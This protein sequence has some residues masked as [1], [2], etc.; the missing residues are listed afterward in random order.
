MIHQRFTAP[1]PT[2]A[3]VEAPSHASALPS[4]GQIT[5]LTTALTAYLASSVSL[6]ELIGTVI[7]PLLARG[8]EYI[9]DLINELPEPLSF[10]TNLAD[11]KTSSAT[12]NTTPA[13][14]VL[15]STTPEDDRKKVIQELILA[16]ASAVQ[17]LL[18]Y[19]I[20]EYKKTQMQPNAGA[21]Q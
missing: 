17:K 20:D 15:A 16:V 9:I 18:T 12:A 11:Q 21:H 13:D 6:I 4:T 2:T 8:I 7:I 19:L 3:S 10:L 14:E 5:A 1:A